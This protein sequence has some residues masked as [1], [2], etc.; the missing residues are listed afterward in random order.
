MPSKQVES[1]EGHGG[2]AGMCTG[3]GDFGFVD[4]NGD[5]VRGTEKLEAEITIREGDVVW[6]LN[7]RTRPEIR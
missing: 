1:A 3:S 4:T 7:G 5:R 6:D 2:I